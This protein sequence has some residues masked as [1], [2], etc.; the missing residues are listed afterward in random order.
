MTQKPNLITVLEIILL[1]KV[2]FTIKILRVLIKDNNI[3]I[4]LLLEF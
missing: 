1:L 3:N 2:T 4:L